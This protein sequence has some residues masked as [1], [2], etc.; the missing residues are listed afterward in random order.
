MNK[1][2][3]F[4]IIFFSAH[5]FSFERIVSINL[6]TDQLL[7]LLEEPE[8]IAS[9]SFLSVDANYS[10]LHKEL[11]NFPT[12]NAQIEEI[13]AYE[14]DLILA[15]NYTEKAVLQFLRQLGYHVEEIAIPENMSHIESG[16]E[17]LGALLDKQE[18]ANAIIADMRLRRLAAQQKVANKPK[19]LAVILAPDGFTHGKGSMNGDLLEL[20]GY[21]NLAAES[22][23]T[24][25]GNISIEQLIQAQ[26]SFL[27]IEDATP[28]RNSLSQRTLEHNA[29]KRGLKNMQHIYV[30]PNLWTCGGPSMINAL[31]ILV[32]SHP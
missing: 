27:I 12:N 8:N 22:G 11:K 28:N 15:G 13:I 9:I 7:Y 31:E 30:H 23:I 25:S 21:R 3:S 4:I 29:L 6:C 24:G 10:Y 1:L 5:S 19:P 16:I 26:P 2:F 17:Q 14:P 18:K 20:A 32:K